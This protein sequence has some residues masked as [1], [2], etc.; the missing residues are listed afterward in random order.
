MTV[1]SGS[2]ERGLERPRRDA[3]M[4]AAGAAMARFLAGFLMAAGR[5]ALPAAPFGTAITAA[6]GTRLAGAGALAGAS[7]GYLV[8]MP[9]E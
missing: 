8:T 2:G 3:A 9:I 5:F 7:L 1:K 6:S 4:Y